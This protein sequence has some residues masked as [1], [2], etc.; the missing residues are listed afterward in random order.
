MTGLGEAHF[1]T[2]LMAMLTGAAVVFRRKGTRSHRWFGR[3]YFAAMLILNLSALGIYRLWGYFGPFHVAAVFSL[4]SVLIGVVV[5]WTRRPAE[6]WRI[7]HAYWMSWSYVGLLAAA[8]SESATR[9]LQLSFGWTVAVAT[10]L[11]MI[12]GAVIINHHLPRMLGLRNRA[13]AGD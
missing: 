6:S 11:V 13:A 10:A 4:L 7:H 9:Y 5:A 1:Y 8:V 12:A 2:A 3:L